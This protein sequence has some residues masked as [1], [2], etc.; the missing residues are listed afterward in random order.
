MTLIHKSLILTIFFL[1]ADLH[2]TQ[3]KIETQYGQYFNH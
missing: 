2:L 3:F 1:N